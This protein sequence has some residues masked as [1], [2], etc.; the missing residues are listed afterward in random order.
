MAWIS[1]ISLQS[2]WISTISLQSTLISLTFSTFKFG[3]CKVDKCTFG[4]P[5]G[6][7]CKLQRASSARWCAKRFRARLRNVQVC[8]AFF[9]LVAAVTCSGVA[10]EQGDPESAN[11]CAGEAYCFMGFSGMATGRATVKQIVV[12]GKRTGLRSP[13]IATG[14]MA[15]ANCGQEFQDSAPVF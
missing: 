10:T 2:A 8:S 4:E 6:S 7:T 13:W 1:T 14:M 11:C 9:V 15:I 5:C 3:K 12:L